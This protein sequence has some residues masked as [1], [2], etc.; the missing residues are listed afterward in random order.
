MQQ[1]NV[2][3][4]QTWHKRVFHEVRAGFGQVGG[5]LIEVAGDR[6]DFARRHVNGDTVRDFEASMLA[7][8]FVFV[9]LDVQFAIDL[10]NLA[11]AVIWV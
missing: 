7:L 4:A 8:E 3:E 1:A 11:V 5:V 9:A 6:Q 10:V 2:V